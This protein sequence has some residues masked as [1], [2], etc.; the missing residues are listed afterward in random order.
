MVL[1]GEYCSCF[2]SY[3]LGNSKNIQI[4]VDGEIISH[5]KALV[6]NN[7]NGNIE[8]LNVVNNIS[9]YITSFNI[10]NGKVKV[11]NIISF[12]KMNYPYYITSKNHN[13]SDSY[14][15]QLDNQELP[16][17]QI[18]KNS[19]YKNLS[20]IIF[21]TDNAIKKN[22]DWI[23]ENNNYYLKNILNYITKNINPVRDFFYYNIISNRS[24]TQ[25]NYININKEYILNENNQ[26]NKINKCDIIKI[27]KKC[28]KM[29]TIYNKELE[30]YVRIN[31]INNK[32]NE[33][34]LNILLS[35]IKKINDQINDKLIDINID[36]DDDDIELNLSSDEE[37]LLIEQYNNDVITLSINKQYND[38]SIE[39]STNDQVIEQ[40]NDQSLKKKTSLSQ[41]KSLLINIDNI[42][43]N[44]L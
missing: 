29:E 5:N 28:K 42:R 2:I 32:N 15:F 10:I 7:L 33:I 17:M 9:N 16:E 23:I 35:K 44:L 43:R 26:N 3:L 36:N 6:S 34:K 4:C 37:N 40:T 22:S 27:Q 30:D 13:I 20:H 18:L 14:Y 1:K 21:S 24:N 39:E 19:Y 41:T 25:L 8:Y 38:K 11:S 31:T 12:Y